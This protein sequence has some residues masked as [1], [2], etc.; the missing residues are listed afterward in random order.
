MRDDASATL[1]HGLHRAGD[2][3]CLP[4]QQLPN[5]RFLKEGGKRLAAG[6]GMSD[7]GGGVYLWDVT[8]PSGAEK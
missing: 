7:A 2:G 3:Q 6:Y 4:A 5:R 8:M 1:T